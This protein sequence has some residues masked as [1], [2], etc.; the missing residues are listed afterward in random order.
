MH[1]ITDSLSFICT[2]S[3]ENWREACAFSTEQAW[4]KWPEHTLYCTLYS[5]FESHQCFYVYKYVDQKKRFGYHAGHQE[6]S[7]CHTRGESKEYIGHEARKHA[8]WLWNPGQTSPEIQNRDKC[9]HIKK[10]WFPP[11]ILK[12]SLCILVTHCNRLVISFQAGWRAVRLC[13]SR[14]SSRSTPAG[15]TTG[16]LGLVHTT[17]DPSTTHTLCLSN[18]MLEACML[19]VVQPFCRSCREKE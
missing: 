10:N 16:S 13:T 14:R 7:R 8:Y 19:S 5:R 15:N 18:Q 1:L 2:E 11:K 17:W 9:G 12:R 3:H 4:H 6:V